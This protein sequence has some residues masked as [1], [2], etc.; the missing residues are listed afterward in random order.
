MDLTNMNIPKMA[1]IYGAIFSLANRMQVLGDKIDSLI[2][3]KQWFVLASVSVFSN[4]PPNIG[5]IAKLLGTSR[6][7]IKKITVILERKGY[8]KLQKDPNDLRNIQLILT[9]KCY[10][11]FK[12]REQQENE[13]INIIFSG[14]DEKMLETLSSGM[15]KLIEN[16]DGMI[17]TKTDSERREKYE[18]NNYLFK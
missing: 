1:F 11:Y 18:R 10:E 14:I 15:A 2:S 16:I 6:Q 9:D 3:T 4:P 7:N 5:D 17:N 12:S 13:Y 8:L